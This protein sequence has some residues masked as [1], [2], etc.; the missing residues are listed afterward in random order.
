[1]PLGLAL[2][3]S[4]CNGWF[5]Q[6]TSTDATKQL[7]DISCPTTSICFAVGSTSD[8]NALIEQSTDSGQ[9]WRELTS[10]QFAIT[11]WAPFIDCPDAEHC[12]AVGG[13]RQIPGGTTYALYTSD[14]GAT[15]SSSIVSTTGN[16]PSG[17]SCVGDSRCFVTEGGN[18][19]TDSQVDVTTDGGSTWTASPK[20]EPTGPGITPAAFGLDSI[21][22][23]SA[24]ECVAEAEE[25]YFTDTEV[26]VLVAYDTLASSTDG[27]AT[28]QQEALPASGGG[29][30][31]CPTATHCLMASDQAVES[32][33]TTDNGSSWTITNEPVPGLDSSFH[34]IS[35]PT[36]VNCVAVEFFPGSEDEPVYTSADGGTTWNSQPIATTFRPGTVELF[37]LDCPSAM[38]CWTVGFAPSSDGTD[39]G[40]IILHSVTGGVAWPSVSSISP[41]QGPV[42]GGTRVTIAGAG[43]LGAPIVT[44]GS[45]PNTEMG[46]NVTVVSSTELQVTAPAWNGTSPPPGGLAVEV[47][48][49]EL[50]LGSSPPNLNYEFTYT[51]T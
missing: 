12:V 40:A 18:D 28:W 16:D 4:G 11:F 49:T 36:A 33:T 15:W 23:V 47:T 2:V 30:V 37:S 45:G 22:C 43:F 34:D 21:A 46:S 10:P 50:G 29:A 25:D 5:T 9:S 17:L 14:G 44:F 3:L 51:S 19:T 42:S 8:N 31:A 7:T 26:P 41:A 39:D 38:S 1:M 6:F 35:C 48:V 20:I 24:T 32:L 13:P 27:G